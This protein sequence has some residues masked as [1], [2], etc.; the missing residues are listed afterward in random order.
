MYLREHCLLHVHYQYY[1]LQQGKV[2]LTSCNQTI[3][4][5]VLSNL[6]HLQ[7]GIPFK[8]CNLL[9]L[10]HFPETEAVDASTAN[11]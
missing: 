6:A 3:H 2:C 4:I 5:S 7:H 1:H 9:Y 10:I 11:P 8:Q